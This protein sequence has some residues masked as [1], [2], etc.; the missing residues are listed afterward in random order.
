MI[1]DLNLQREYWTRRDLLKTGGVLAAALGVAACTGSSTRSIS[2]PG[3]AKFIQPNELTSNNGLLELTLRC[4]GQTIPYGNGTR[5]AYTYN[6]TSPGPTLRVRSGDRLVI[7]LENRLSE[8][9]NLHTHGLH[10]SPLGNSDNVFIQIAPGQSHVYTYDIPSDHRSSLCWYHPHHHGMVAP[11]LGGGLFGAIIVEDMHEQ[12]AE[13]ANINERVLIL[14]D[15]KIGKNNA[16]T[17]ASMME[18][19]QG[20]EGGDALVNGVFA[21]MLS[22][23]AG[24]LELWRI[25]NASPSRYYRLALDKQQLQ[26]IGTDGGRLERPYAVDDILLAPGERSDILV[27]PT[28]QGPY[29]LR[30]LGYDRGSMGMG[31]G[32]MGGGSTRSSNAQIIATLNVSGSAPAAPLPKVLAAAT[33]LDAGSATSQ[34][35]IELAVGMGGG[36][37]NGGMM[38]F[39]INGATFDANRVDISAS[40]GSTEDWV[41]TNTS[42]MDHPFHLHAWP[43]RVIERSSGPADPPGWKDTVNVPARG[44]VRI[45]I[46]FVDITGRTVYHCHILD[47]EDQG[48]M[49]VIEV[50]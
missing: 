20:R 38:D 22:A 26:I 43:F 5:F 47:H 49:G 41:L 45:R 48:M 12:V 31:G 3:G 11:Q 19:M 28:Q 34:R 23:P 4:E 33:R 2:T 44:S 37:G 9:T 6:G 42:A 39:T 15:P 29:A 8:P 40:A 36:M 27:A 14:N 50:A 7:T 1:E 18:K 32:M 46:P 21:P 30:T 35:D 17:N 25:V 16:V 13:L 10:V 24:T